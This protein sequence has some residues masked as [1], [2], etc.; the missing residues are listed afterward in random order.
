M[1]AESSNSQK[2]LPLGRDSSHSFTEYLHRQMLQDPQF[3]VGLMECHDTSEMMT[4][5]L[6]FN[7]Y[8]ALMLT[9]GTIVG[10]MPLISVRK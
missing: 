7:F 1:H 8:F 2:H 6:G 10:L 3:I 4:V 9:R 5:K